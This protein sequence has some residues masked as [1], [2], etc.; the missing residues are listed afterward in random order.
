MK[1]LNRDELELIFDYCLGTADFQQREKARQLIDSNPEAADFCAK[2]KSSIG[3]LDEWTVEPCPDRLVEDTVSYVN[4]AAR[5]SQ[6]KLGELLAFE[7][8]RT[9][10]PRST[11]WINIGRRLAMAAVFM[12][13]GGAALTTMRYMRYHAWLTQ[14]QAQLAGMANGISN[15]SADYNG[16][17]PAV[18]MSTGSPW[19]K[20]GDQGKENVS[21]TRG[22]WLL[23]KGNYVGPNEFLCPGAKIGQLE[24]ITDKQAKEL[25]DFPNRKYIPYSLRLICEKSPSVSSLGR[26][27]IISDMNPLFENLP[28]DFGRPLELKLDEKLLKV[29]SNNHQRKGQNLLFS[30]GSVQYV[31]TRRVGVND[32]DIFTLRGT[33]V[34]KGC[35]VPSCDEDEFMAP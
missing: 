33:D 7:E 26:K 35:E 16:R 19:W 12:I 11:L 8:S 29:N 20:V 31:N 14:C 17:L 18:A 1:E 13:V 23:V 24:P 3:P 10:A 6:A 2:V 9:P 22:I 30:D 27:L 5:N 32:D 28:T 25:F 4:Q 34:Y 15:Y 21:N